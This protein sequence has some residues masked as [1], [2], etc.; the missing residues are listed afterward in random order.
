ME[1]GMLLCAVTEEQ[2][3]QCSALLLSDGISKTSHRPHIPL[4]VCCS[5]IFADESINVY[6]YMCIYI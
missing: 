4:L 2:A 3:M 5:L 1:F 6:I